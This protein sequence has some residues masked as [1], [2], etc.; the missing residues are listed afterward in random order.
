MKIEQHADVS[1]VLAL[2]PASIIGAKLIGT[3]ACDCLLTV[4]PVRRE[5]LSI[6]I[7]VAI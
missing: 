5:V 3:S 2:L 6:L 1:E 4:I 7:D